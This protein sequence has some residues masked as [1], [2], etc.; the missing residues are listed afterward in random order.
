MRILQ[1]DN[2]Q[3]HRFGDLRVSTS[4]KLYH[5]LIRG[6]HK[7]L[8]FS[9]R[10]LARFEAPLKVKPLGK[11]RANRRL[12]ETCENYQPQMILLGHAG[13]Y[14]QSNASRHQATPP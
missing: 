3:W 13:P 8:E 11:H 9:D 10:D 7:V 4:R 14:R 1:V 6:N 2:W 5:G 12:I